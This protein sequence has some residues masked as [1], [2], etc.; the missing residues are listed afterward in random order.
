MSDIN[1]RKHIRTKLR[2]DVTLSH[3][4]MG[5][6]SL[7]TGDFSDGG[8]YIFSDGQELPV[9]GELVNVQVQGMAGGEAPILKMRIVRID[10]KGIGLQ[11]TGEE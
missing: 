3:P 8:V 6:L 7:H 5:D 10:K 4:G 2:A 1:K 11:F 9:M